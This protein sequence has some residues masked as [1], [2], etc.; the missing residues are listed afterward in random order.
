M[1]MPISLYHMN[2]KKNIKYMKKKMI[3][4]VVFN[5]QNVGL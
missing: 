3:R 5:F 2:I 1:I 4:N